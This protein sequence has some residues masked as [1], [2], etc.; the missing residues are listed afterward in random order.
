MAN[1]VGNSFRLSQSFAILTNCRTDAVPD[2]SHHFASGAGAAGGAGASST[3]AAGAAA[4]AGADTP[5]APLA[6]PPLPQ[7]W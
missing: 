4:A 1:G 3:F 7:L 6:Q 2:K 5:Q